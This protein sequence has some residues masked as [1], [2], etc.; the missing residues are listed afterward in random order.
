[1]TPALMTPA[2]MTRRE[3]G[4]GGSA[5]DWGTEDCY[6]T[7]ERDGGR[8]S[9]DGRGPAG[10]GRAASYPWPT[11]GHPHPRWTAPLIALAVAL[12][13]L[14]AVMA[15][16]GV[17]VGVAPAPADGA[18]GTDAGIAGSY[19]DRARDEVPSVV[20]AG[21]DLPRWALRG[22]GPVLLAAGALLAALGS[23]RVR[24]VPAAQ[25]S[26]PVPSAAHVRRRGPPS[27][28]V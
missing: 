3:D 5:T 10:P 4:R 9:S 6:H 7:T 22:G 14:A 1:M 28:L 21:V 11:M 8:C 24:P 2:L 15:Q 19:P 16:A 20:P 23:T 27:L 12:L 13:A 25:I 18:S 17:D 26:V